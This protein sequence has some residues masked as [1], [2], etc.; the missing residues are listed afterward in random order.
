VTGIPLRAD[1][2]RNR[3]RVVATAETVFARLGT[4]TSVE[5]VARAA[6]VGPATVY[7]HFPRKDDLISAVLRGYFER[8]L[9]RADDA[10]QAPDER[11]IPVFLVTVGRDLAAAGGLAHGLWGDLAPRDL[12]AELEQLTATLVERARA[13]GAI[14]ATITVED[15]AAT[16][17]A[18]RGV[19]DD[20]RT[21]WLRHIAI[22]VA[23]LKQGPDPAVPES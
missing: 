8:L 4:D 16:V 10:I 6:G 11:C 20:G 21:D 14:A 19:I 13:A 9:R 2:V 5:D 7:R 17:R 15:I 22:T 23:G 3:A 18:L 1:A 12:V